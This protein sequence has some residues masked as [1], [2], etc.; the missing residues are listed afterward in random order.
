VYP[1][2][3]SRTAHR[4]RLRRC[5]W[6]RLVRVGVLDPITPV[7]AAQEIVDALPKGIATLGVV[8]GAGHFPWKDAPDR[9]WPLVTGFVTTEEFIAGVP[10]G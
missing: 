9:C 7:A 1:S 6:S 8:E 2:S 5:A 3:G 10:S 4:R